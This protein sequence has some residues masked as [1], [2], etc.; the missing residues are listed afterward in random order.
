MDPF[1]RHG[2]VLDAMRE[3]A[4][5]GEPVLS[6]AQSYHNFQ[7]TPM[8]LAFRLRHKSDQI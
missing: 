5:K 6:Q 7:Q 4:F 1:F 2:L 3:P 8:L